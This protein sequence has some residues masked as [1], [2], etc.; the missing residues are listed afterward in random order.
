MMI[1]NKKD[2][3]KELPYPWKRCA[4]WA[5]KDIHEIQKLIIDSRF[6]YNMQDSKLL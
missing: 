1:K 5:K 2:T 3:K 6:D 4:C